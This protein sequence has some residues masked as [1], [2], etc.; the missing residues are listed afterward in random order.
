MR[1]SS[2][3]DSL[4]RSNHII[5]HSADKLVFTIQCAHPPSKRHPGA[6]TISEALP[7]MKSVC[8]SES[9]REYLPSPSSRPAAVPRTL[10]AVAAELQSE[11]STCEQSQ[12]VC[13]ELCAGPRSIAVCPAHKG[14]YRCTRHATLSTPRSH[15]V[16]RATSDVSRHL[17]QQSLEQAS[18]YRGKSLWCYS[19]RLYG[20]SGRC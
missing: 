12:I 20:M 1:S 10:Q 7:Y 8:E 13:S 16:S 9:A 11:P 18:P 19:R 2:K 3:L 15:P 4:F 5:L 6:T 14:R 17:G